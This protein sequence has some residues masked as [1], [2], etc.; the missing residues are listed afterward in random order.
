MHDRYG[1]KSGS[2]VQMVILD[3]SQGFHTLPLSDVAFAAN[4][5]RSVHNFA[6]RSF[7]S[8]MCSVAIPT[9]FAPFAS[10]SCINE[11]IWPPVSIHSS[12]HASSISLPIHLASTKVGTHTTITFI[13]GLI[14]SL[15]T[16]SIF[17]FFTA[18]LLIP[19]LSSSR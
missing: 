17:S 5:L 3:R 16:S 11:V 10:N 19:L 7:E 12:L 8:S 9:T 13:P 15:R 14:K 1:R 2:Q 6:P 4:T 18:V